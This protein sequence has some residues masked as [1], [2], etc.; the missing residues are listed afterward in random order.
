MA[1]EETIEDL[2][3]KCIDYFVE[4]G[5]ER[6]KTSV[7]DFKDYILVIPDAIN[8]YFEPLLEIG[9]TE[10]EIRQQ[11]IKDV[12]PTPDYIF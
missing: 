1:V 3:Q 4:I 9:F 2:T 7:T 10:R 8:K 11:V 6:S 12:E 5:A